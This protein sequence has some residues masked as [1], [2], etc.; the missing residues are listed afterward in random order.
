MLL[1]K[2]L[3]PPFPQLSENSNS[4]LLR[5]E[6]GYGQQDSPGLVFSRCFLTFL[7]AQTNISLLWHSKALS[8]SS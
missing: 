4:D 3:F 5:S 1:S 2:E 7:V 8:M 6:C